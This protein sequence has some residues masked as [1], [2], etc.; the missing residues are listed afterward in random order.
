MRAALL[1]LSTQ[2]AQAQDEGGVCRSVVDALH[3]EAFGFDGVGLFLAGSASFEPALK[4]SAG[5]FGAGGESVSELKVPLRIDHS[6]IG[7]LVVQ[8][9][10]S[11]AFDK[12]DL[13]I[14]G[15]AAAPGGGAGPHRRAARAP[16]DPRRPL[17]RAGAGQAATGRP[18]AGRLAARRDRR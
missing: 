15:A 8:R 4:A 12:G 3:H 7:E 16:G 11:R 5:A 10:R 17:R 6:A 13:E 2:I 18:G 14:L 1:N 9:G